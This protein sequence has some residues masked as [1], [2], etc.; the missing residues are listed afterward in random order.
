MSPVL[1]KVF[2][3]VPMISFRRPRNLKVNLVRAKMQPLEKKAKGMFC[4]EKTT[5]CKVCN[6]VNRAILLL[7]MLTSGLSTS[8]ILLIVTRVVSFI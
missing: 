4:W 7:V 8:I 6:Y 1:K 3:E 2:M 5:R